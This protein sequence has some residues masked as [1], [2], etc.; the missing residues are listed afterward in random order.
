[1][2]P[3]SPTD[4]LF[5]IGESREH[6]MHVGSLQLFK[7]PEDAGP[8]YVRDSYQSMLESTEVQPTFRKHPAFFGLRRCRL[9]PQRAASAA[10]TKPLGDVAERSGADVRRLEILLKPLGRARI[11]PKQPLWW[12]SI[13]RSPRNARCHRNC[14]ALG[15]PACHYLDRGTGTQRIP[16]SAGS[17]YDRVQPSPYPCP[18]LETDDVKIPAPAQFK[19]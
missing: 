18:L 4:A 8:H 7:P 11:G 17:A 12:E 15:T 2:K 13:E 1:M 6:P 3:I 5:L 19:S 14:T 16:R 9:P 10:A